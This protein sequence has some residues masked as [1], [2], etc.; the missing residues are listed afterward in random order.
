MVVAVVTVAAAVA[1][2]NTCVSETVLS[3]RIHTS[4]Y[5]S[6]CLLRCG[7]FCVLYLE[8]RMRPREIYEV[9]EQV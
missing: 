6:S 1:I 8:M 7:N 3:V 5:F 4:I 9:A 2:A